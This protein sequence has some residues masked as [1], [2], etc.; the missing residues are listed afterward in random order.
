MNEDRVSRQRVLSII[1][2]PFFLS[3]PDQTLS[4][5]VDDESP[6]ESILQLKYPAVPPGTE[7]CVA[8]YIYAVIS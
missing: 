8:V 4:W 1:A 5:L 2:N 3:Y 6:D 7:D